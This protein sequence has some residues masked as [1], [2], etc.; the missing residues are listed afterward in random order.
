MFLCHSELSVSPLHCLIG[1]CR[2]NF[3]PSID[4]NERERKTSTA[5][6]RHSWEEEEELDCVSNCALNSPTVHVYPWY[7]TD[8]TPPHWCPKVT[9]PGHNKPHNWNLSALSP[10]ILSGVTLKK[11]KKKNK[12]LALCHPKQ[13]RH[14]HEMWSHITGTCLADT[15][16]WTE[17][18]AEHLCLCLYWPHME[19][20]ILLYEMYWWLY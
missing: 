8:I 11:I 10:S 3:S 4:S 18:T 12:V 14:T 19:Y 7:E 5:V 1:N 16:H 9:S 13:Q 20:D 15:K 2:Q 6:L 17:N